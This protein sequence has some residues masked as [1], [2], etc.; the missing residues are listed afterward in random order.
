MHFDQRQYT[1]M[2]MTITITR[3]LKVLGA[4]IRFWLLTTP[5]QCTNLYTCKSTGTDR[6]AI[7]YTAAATVALGIDHQTT[8][9]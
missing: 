4:M 3:T 6:N 8:Q 2:G 5:I 7:A 1:D 9:A